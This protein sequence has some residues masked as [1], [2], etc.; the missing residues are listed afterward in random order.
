MKTILSLAAILGLSVSAAMAFDIPRGVHEIGELE[1][2]RSK[3][4]DKNKPVVFLFSNKK[5]EP[6]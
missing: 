1:E 3:A 2:A 6:S 5:L 4:A